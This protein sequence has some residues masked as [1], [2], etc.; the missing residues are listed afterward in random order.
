MTLKQKLLAIKQSNSINPVQ[1]GLVEWM[2]NC[3]YVTAARK[4]RGWGLYSP[5]YINQP[6]LTWEDYIL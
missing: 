5:T 1:L 6:A 2:L 3:E 4:K